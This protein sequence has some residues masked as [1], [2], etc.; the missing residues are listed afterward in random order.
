VSG[1][2]PLSFHPVLAPEDQARA[3]Y[4]ALL[5]RLYYAGPDAALLEAIA[6]ADEVIAESHA[7]PLA[8]AWRALVAAAMA[9]DADAAREE[10]DGA[11]V[12]TGKAEVT[13]YATY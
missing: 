11:F 10:Y 6:R 13:P 5:S 8:A 3:G 12:G 7:T 9:M 1:A 2:A 4:Y